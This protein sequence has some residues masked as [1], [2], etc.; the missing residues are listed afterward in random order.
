M[1]RGHHRNNHSKHSSHH[2]HSSSH[3]HSRHHN[4]RKKFSIRKFL[5]IPT[6]IFKGIVLLVLGILLLRFSGIIF[7]DW[8]N[9]VE[10]VFWGSFIGIVFIIA[11]IL[12]FVAWWRN[13]ILQHRIGVKVGGW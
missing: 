3:N 5:G 10:G 11:G 1:K 12:C 13:N 4:H 7:I 2:R 6:W 8:L 9:W